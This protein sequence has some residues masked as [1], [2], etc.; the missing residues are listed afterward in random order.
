MGLPD[1]YQIPKNNDTIISKMEI[2]GIKKKSKHSSRDVE[3]F[4][5]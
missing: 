5:N 3:I 4:L 2:L 1:L